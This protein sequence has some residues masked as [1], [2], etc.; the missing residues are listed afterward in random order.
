MKSAQ[1]AVPKMAL[2]TNKYES[3]AAQFV[4]AIK[5]YIELASWWCYNTKVVIFSIIEQGSKK[6][7]TVFWQF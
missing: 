2:H 1:E 3:G 4:L 5:G 7:T 6:G